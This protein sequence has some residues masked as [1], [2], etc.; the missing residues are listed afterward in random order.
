MESSC[1]VD[2]T[3]EL[4]ALTLAMSVRPAIP[5]RMTDDGS[6][7]SAGSAE[8]AAAAGAAELPAA[9]VVHHEPVVLAWSRI[10]CSVPKVPAIMGDQGSTLGTV[11][12][13]DRRRMEPQDLCSCQP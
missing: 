1:V 7:S 5:S 13:L 6:R 3:I 11:G 4:R 2:L 9:A 10:S 12:V 8:A